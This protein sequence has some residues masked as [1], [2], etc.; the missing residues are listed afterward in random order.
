MREAARPRQ[1]KV[2][3]YPGGPQTRR[4]GRAARSRPSRHGHLARP[5]RKTDRGCL[6]L[7]AASGSRRPLVRGRSG[8]ASAGVSGRPGPTARRQ[9]GGYLIGPHDFVAVN[10]RCCRA[11]SGPGHARR[12]APCV[13]DRNRCASSR[14]RSSGHRSRASSCA[15]GVP[16][17][18]PITGVTSNSPAMG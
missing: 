18:H 15:L 7:E 14:R 12:S 3:G 11:H 4:T 8:G 17:P 16:A 2:P 9:P 1:R 5:G 6:G 13:G 10:R